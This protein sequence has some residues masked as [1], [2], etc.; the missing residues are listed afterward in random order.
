MTTAEHATKATKS[1]DAMLYRMAEKRAEAAS[2]N[3]YAE[4]HRKQRKG[5]RK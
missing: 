3:F 2:R 1:I 5:R 4:P